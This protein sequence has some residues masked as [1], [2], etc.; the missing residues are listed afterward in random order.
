M[1][2]LYEFDLNYSN[3]KNIVGVDE[4]GRGPLAGPVVASAVILD[5]SNPIPGINDS[6][7]ISEKKRE[8]LFLKI[9]ENALGIGIGIVGHLE[10][11]T[12]NI[13]NATKKAM[14]TAIQNLKMNFEIILTD[15]TKLDFDQ[16]KVEPIIKGD[17]KSA[18][19]AAASIIAKVTRDRIMKELDSLYPL[20][21]F[22][23]HKG[24]P[25]Q[26]HRKLLE[27]YG[28]C[29]VHRKTFSPVRQLLS[30]S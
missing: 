9:Q 29:E 20:Y 6:K 11:D 24:Y 28:P 1:S 8:E 14:I 21:N 17:S 13:L 12:I 23:Q 5:L 15:A 30:K 4:A 19:I 16:Y 7:K 22:K 10:I 18:S 26:R 25:T 2:A 27:Q 3:T